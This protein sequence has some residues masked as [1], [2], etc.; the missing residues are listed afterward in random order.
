MNFIKTWLRGWWFRLCLIVICA[1]LMFIDIH[2]DLSSFGTL[3]LISLILAFIFFI[4]FLITRSNKS[5]N[6][7]K[8]LLTMVIS[9]GALWIILLLLNGLDYFYYLDFDLE[10]FVSL[11]RILFFISWT[12]LLLRLVW[13]KR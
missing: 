7:I 11:I 13:R 4:V 10:F 8:R 5:D 9:S 2:F 1:I 3:S 6:W 12:F